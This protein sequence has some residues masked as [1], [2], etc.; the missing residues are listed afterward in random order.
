MVRGKLDIHMQKML[1]TYLTP[2][3]KINSK[4][5][6]NL[7]LRVKSKKKI[8]GEKLHDNSFGEDS[9][10][11]MLKARMAKEKLD[12]LEIIRIESYCA[13]DTS[14]IEEATHKMGENVCKS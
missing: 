10:E 12:K 9:W 14:Q 5:V 7:N 8:L 11:M 13:K 4:W 1:N 6:K 2:H 3:I